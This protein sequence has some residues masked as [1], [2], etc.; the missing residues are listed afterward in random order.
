MN[1][2]PSNTSNTSSSTLPTPASKPPTRSRHWNW[3]EKFLPILS[4]VLL[5][6]A[7]AI[8]SPHFLTLPNLS[9]VAR[10]TAVINIMALGMTLI[11]I[12]GGID[13]SVGSVM[14]FSGIAGTM[15]L[16]AGLP[17]PVAILGA[18]VAG[19]GWPGD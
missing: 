6:V 8:L 16:Q 19:R 3:L 2:G 10:R 15:L 13:L 17:L 4:L 18:M 5:F 7:L 1:T 14:A 11:I 9:N 12:S